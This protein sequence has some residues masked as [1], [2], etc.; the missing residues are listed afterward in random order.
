MKRHLIIIVFALSAIAMRAQNQDMYSLMYY[1]SIHGNILGFMQQHDGDFLINTYLL[2]DVGGYEYIPLGYRFLK[3]SPNTLAITDSLFVADTTMVPTCSFAP[4]PHGEG[5]IRTILEY[6]G[7]CDSTFLRISHLPDND[8]HVDPS[9][10]V[11][12][13]LCKGFVSGGCNSMV[14]SRGDIILQYYKYSGGGWQLDE[15]AARFGLDGTLDCQTLLRENIM[16]GVCRLQVLKESPLTYYEWGMAQ[17]GH[18]GYQNLNVFVIDSL[19]NNNPVLISSLLSEEAID[20]NVFVYEHLQI[21]GDTQVIPV[22][23]DDVMVAAKY[24]KDTTAHPTT[25]EYGVVVAKY[26]IRTMELKDYV[27]FNDFTSIYRPAQCLGLKMMTDGTVYFLYKEDGYPEESFVAVKMDTNLNVDWKRLCKTE[28]VIIPS[29]FSHS[30]L[31]IDE[32]GDEKGIA[33][34]GYGIKAD[35]PDSRLICLL[36]NHD[37]PVNSQNE[38]VVSVRPY[39]FYPNPVKDQLLMQFSPDV[40]P[41][42]VEL[43]D[44]QGRLVR[45]QSKAFESIDMNQL[46]AGTY[47][48]RVTLEDGKSYSDKVV[49]E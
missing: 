3:A 11:V 38:G 17:T 28:D 29:W 41:D 43:Y 4:N 22:G 35:N 16:Y 9:Q 13:P 40:Q 6:H 10:D 21:D 37:G 23:G 18:N 30:T 32:Q 5:S 27:V 45:S 12:V 33:W 34:F 36:F 47:T 2:E 24:V 20:H 48:L 31:N 49:K 15:Y 44:L 1:D 26:N 8:L 42:K 46:P 14:D 39:C 25:A 7:E 19:L